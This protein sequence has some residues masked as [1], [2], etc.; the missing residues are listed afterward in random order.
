VTQQFREF[1]KVKIRERWPLEFDLA[2]IPRETAVRSQLKEQ[3]E[4]EGM[5]NAPSPNRFVSGAVVDIN[6]PAREPY[7]PR[8]PKNEFPKILYHP[9]LKHPQWEAEYKRIVKYNAL[10]PEKPELL[11]TV[12]AKQVKVNNKQE[13]EAKIKDGW[14]FR[15]PAIAPAP[16]EEAAD[17]EG[18]VLCSRGCGREPHPGRCKAA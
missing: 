17:D 14:Q 13:E 11:P 7:N 3:Y 9:T 12:P 2:G 8:D 16:E 10:H 1:R 18:Q 6:A 4:E 5:P 15:P